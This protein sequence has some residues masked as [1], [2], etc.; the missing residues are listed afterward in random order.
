MTGQPGEGATPPMTPERL[1]R[2]TLEAIGIPFEVIEI[3]PAFADTA[4]FCDRYG[5][6][7]EQS[8][9]TIVVSSKKE[10]KKYIACVVLATTQLDVNRRAKKLLGVSK[11]SFAGPDEMKTLTGMAVGGVTPFSLPPGISLFVDARIMELE[12][13]IVGGG[14]RGMKVK[15]APEAFTRA[16]ASVVEDLGKEIR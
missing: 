12:W 16:G 10:P 14:G 1:V 3:D 9:N 8:C 2:E 7:R 11:A 15:I 5:Y 4:A 6:P 13:V